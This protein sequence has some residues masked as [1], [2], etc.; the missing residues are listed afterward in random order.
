[1]D[2]AQDSR[3]VMQRVLTSDE[4][5]YSRQRLEAVQSYSSV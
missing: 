2:Y 3:Q 4:I 1:M 5:C